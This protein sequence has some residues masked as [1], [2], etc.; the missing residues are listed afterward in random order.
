VDTKSQ[1]EAEFGNLP[2]TKGE[3]KE[4]SKVNQDD[5]TE[6]DRQEEITMVEQEMK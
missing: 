1:E 3:E 5:E 6:I 2:N 4:E